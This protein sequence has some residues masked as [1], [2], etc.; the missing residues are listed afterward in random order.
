MIRFCPLCH[1]E[2]GEPSRK[3][4]YTCPTEPEKCKAQYLHFDCRGRL[5]RIVYTGVNVLPRYGHAPSMPLEVL[6]G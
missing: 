5:K 6:K 2:L 3:G 1:A 4:R